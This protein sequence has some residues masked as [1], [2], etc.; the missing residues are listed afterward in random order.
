[1]FLSFTG[2]VKIPYEYILHETSSGSFS[3]HQRKNNPNRLT[4]GGDIIIHT[5]KH[6]DDMDFLLYGVGLK[7][8]TSHL[9]MYL[10]DRGMSLKVQYLTL[11]FVRGSIFTDLED[12]HLL[13]H[14][15]RGD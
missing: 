8:L 15:A 3:I 6:T 10:L 13:N 2:Q 9:I 1:M 11:I 14:P 4:I 12:P 5:K 7:L